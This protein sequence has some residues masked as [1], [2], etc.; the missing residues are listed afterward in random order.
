MIVSVSLCPYTK[1]AA[2]LLLKMLAVIGPN[3]ILNARVI[4][5]LSNTWQM[6]EADILMQKYG[7]GTDS[8]SCAS[9]KTDLRVEGLKRLVRS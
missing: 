9:L 6:A 4:P 5:C 1:H 2:T 3:G 8:L 7:M